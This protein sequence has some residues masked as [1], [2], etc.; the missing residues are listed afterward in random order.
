MGPLPHLIF[1]YLQAARSGGGGGG[2]RSLGEVAISPIHSLGVSANRPRVSALIHYLWVY[3]PTTQVSAWG[4][5]PLTA[6]VCV[7]AFVFEPATR[8]T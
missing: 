1:S 5:C 8:P 7:C 6:P 2:L 4:L 3:Q